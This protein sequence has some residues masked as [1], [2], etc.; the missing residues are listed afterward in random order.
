MA[1]A[2]NEIARLLPRAVDYP[3]SD[4]NLWLKPTRTAPK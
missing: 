4:A 3:A 2:L 1:T